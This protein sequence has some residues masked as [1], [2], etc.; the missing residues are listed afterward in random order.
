MTSTIRSFDR[1]PHEEGIGL[2]SERLSATS[3]TDT[4]ETTAEDA[5]STTLHAF[6]L[7]IFPTDVHGFICT[8]KRRSGSGP[9]VGAGRSF[10]WPNELPQLLSW[11][12]K[13]RSDHDLYFSPMLYRS[14]KRNKEHVEQT[15]VLWADLDTCTP[16]QLLIEP[17]AIWETSAG[18]YQAV[19]SLS[20]QVE[21]AQAEAL[22]RS[23]YEAHKAYGC[24]S[25]WALGK[26]LRV[27]GTI[28]FKRAVPEQVSAPAYCVGAYT[29]DQL[30]S[31][32][33]LLPT[34]P[35]QMP[36]KSAEKFEGQLGTPEELLRRYNAGDW[37]WKA[38][39]SAPGPLDDWSSISWTF[40]NRLAEVGMSPD[41]AFHVMRS[42]AC[43]KYARD[44]RP[45]TDLMRE[46]DR[47]IDNQSTKR[48]TMAING[49]VQN[50]NV[51]P[52]GQLRIAYRFIAEH[53]RSL[54][55]VHGL[56][57]HVW[58]GTHWKPDD[59]GMPMRLA[60]ATVE[61][62]RLEAATLPETPRK[63]LWSDAS[64]CETDSGL[65]GVLSIA[66]NLEPMA[67]R[68]SAL[69]N[70]PYL[71]NTINGTL[72]LRTMQ[73]SAHD[74][75]HLITK[76]SGCH[77]SPDAEGI[78]FLRFLAEI[79]PDEEVRDFVQRLFG[80]SLL[81][82]VKEHVLPLFIGSGR[83]GKSK[84]LEVVLR[85]FGDYGL[86]AAPT[87]LI[88]KGAN[89]NHSDKVDLRGR[90][91]VVCSETDE[92]HRFA[93]GTVKSLTGG[94]EVS[95]RPL[96]GKWLTFA[97]SHTIFLMT[98]HPPRTDGSDSA[99]FERLRKISFEQSF[100]GERQDPNLSEKLD[101][102]RDVV[103]RW[104]V[105][106]YAKYLQRGLT[107]PAKVEADTKK[108]QLSNDPLGEFLES[109]TV[110][111]EYGSVGTT[112]LLAAWTSWGG[113]K[114]SAKAFSS[115]IEERG[116]EKKKTRTN[117]CFVGMDLKEL[118]TGGDE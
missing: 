111:N 113:P 50:I 7:H 32:L 108:Y 16:S 56:G 10:R 91:I 63:A 11:V 13:Y 41:E 2:P 85:A 76:V 43:N 83:N 47:A 105:E 19:W 38:Y 40:A 114:M 8:G 81:G 69:D 35:T 6:F 74:A 70:D 46:I 95:A 107:L 1:S 79:L 17:T 3:G 4:T 54:R 61:A 20:E 14:R 92:G 98:N 30:S 103:L 37:V 23:V 102:E 84:L 39:Q 28:N 55:F 99:M 90:R 24:D 89:G 94:D 45:D 116:Y 106:G 115:R 117:N 101:L 12:D 27:P 5:Q 68:V 18:S 97:P 88:E 87:L 80:Y 75:A 60:V 49:Q 26:L 77:Y 93:A 67:V 51:Q 86:M 66:E 73:L 72:D 112:E 33:P 15:P 57:W 59:D 62:A 58:T 42:A 118:P 78:T 21:P 110:R 104:T 64:K 25:G 29:T 100:T 82:N 44:G 9:Q 31:R 34:P 22:S 71:F 48:A 96:Y 109:C 36:S 53:K 52:R 65:R